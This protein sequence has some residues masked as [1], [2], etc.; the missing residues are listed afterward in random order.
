MTE[1]AKHIFYSVKHV[2]SSAVGPWAMKKNLLKG[3]KYELK[4]STGDGQS[5][6]LHFESC[7][8][9]MTISFSLKLKMLKGVAFIQRRQKSGNS[10]KL[11]V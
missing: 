4:F 1:N 11:F 5:V 2:V 7:L 8:G 10:G 3:I 9:F 6:Y